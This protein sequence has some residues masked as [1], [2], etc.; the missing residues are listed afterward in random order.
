MPAVPLL[1]AAG[2]GAASPLRLLS[3]NVHW[4]CGSDHIKGCRDAAAAR[5]AELARGAGAGVV[6]AI[7]LEADSETPLDLTLRGLQGW[8]QVNGSCPG[9]A[10]RTGDAL[11]LA[12]APGYTVAASGGGCLGGATAGGYTADA[13]A[14]AVARVVPPAPVRGCGAGVCLVA[15]HSP[16]INITEGAAVV[17]RVCGPQRHACTVA[18]GDWN[19]PIWAAPPAWEHGANATDRWAQL[20][21]GPEPA[22][23]APDVNTCCYPES[24]YR[25]TDD[26]VLTNIPG[27]AVQGARA[28]GY[29]MMATNDTEEHM[30]VAVNLT[31]PSF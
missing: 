8:S 3:W 14:F 1:L 17:A 24:K 5:L 20:I 31:L 6:A 16:H 28:L 11:A 25:G 7:E 15:L 12:V 21:G 23:G 26:H 10:G 19:A 9:A 18:M 22:V 2:A 27:A 30:P 29:Q 13:R 4:Q